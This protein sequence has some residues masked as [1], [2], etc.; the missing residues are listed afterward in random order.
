[1]AR[2]FLLC[3]H[4]G[5][6]ETIDEQCFWIRCS[7]EAHGSHGRVGCWQGGQTVSY[8]RTS[9]IYINRQT[10]LLNVLAQRVDVGVI[11]GD[12]F[13]N[14]QSCP[15]DFQAQ[16]YVVHSYRGDNPLIFDPEP[17]VSNK[18]HMSDPQPF[19]RP[20]C[21][22]LSYASR[23]RFRC[24]RR[25]HSTF[26]DYERDIVPTEL[27]FISVDTCIELCGL[28]PYRNAAVGSLGIENRKRTTIAV[29]LAAK[30]S[31]FSF[32][33][34]SSLLRCSASPNSCSF[35]TSQPLALTPRVHGT[36]SSS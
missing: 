28:G 20:F 25:S 19:R 36:L 9:L 10:T 21:S 29:E 23:R 31:S 30:V 8:L 3:T 11:T 2:A 15:K 13:V 24:P 14:G 6:T 27:A 26:C 12:R 32:Y 4:R 5:R 16:T 22:P 33:G 18:I 34:G 35:W 7:W 17:I 1:M